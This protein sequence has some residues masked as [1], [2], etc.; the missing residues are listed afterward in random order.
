MRKTTLV[1]DDDLLRGAQEAL[2][3]RG[4]KATVD[5][6]FIEAIAMSARREALRQLREL[7]G[8]ELADESVMKD[9]WR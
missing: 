1:I 5:R 7:D 2:G 3:T 6:A 9:A 4:L 8:L